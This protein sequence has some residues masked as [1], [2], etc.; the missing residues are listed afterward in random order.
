MSFDGFRKRVRVPWDHRKKCSTAGTIGRRFNY[1]DIRGHTATDLRNTDPSAAAWDKELRTADERPPDLPP[2]GPSRAPFFIAAALVVVAAIA[3]YLVFGRRAPQ[4]APTGAAST[5]SAKAA[6]PQPL[7]GAGDPIELPPLADTDPLVRDLVRKLT[8][9]PRLTAWLATEGLIRNFTVVV[10]NVAGGQKF[11]MLLGPMRPSAPFRVVERDDAIS[12]DPRSYERYTSLADGVSA[13]DAQGTARLYATLK[14]RIEDAYRELGEPEPSFDRTLE[15]A[16][17]VLL[18]TPVTA[19][20][21]HLKPHGGTGY[22]FV[23]DR[24]EALTPAQKLLLRMGPQNA[25]A[26]QAKLR[27]IALALGVPASRLPGSGR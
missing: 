10:T 19:E 21:V 11:A 13:I 20:L 3:V 4:Q 14:P 23:D 15:R 16:M 25:R 26:I 6:A 2:D 9:H 5:P 8:T 24:L 22:G 7:G 12:V 27:E 17:A 1:S 18:A